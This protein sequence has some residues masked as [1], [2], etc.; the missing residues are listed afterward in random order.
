VPS[1]DGYR[2]QAFERLASTNLEAMRQAVAGVEGNLWIT[3]DTQS[4]GK[5]RRGRIWVSEP[6]N[7]YASLL[8]MENGIQKGI[9]TLPFVASLAVA[10][11]IRSCLKTNDA[12][13]SIKWPNDVLF[14]R[15][16]ISGILLEA[17]VL[18][19]EKH[20]VVIGCGINCM[21]SPENALYPATSLK[22]E[23][24]STK[25]DEMFERLAHFMQYYLE[26]LDQGRGFAP[27]RKKWLAQAAGLGEP[28]VARFDDYTVSGTFNGID[29][30]GLMILTTANGEKLISAADIFF[31][32]S[33]KD[34]GRKQ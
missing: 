18:S 16:K 12:P 14:D 23:G 11:A 13:V 21:H 6:G 24:Y 22:D 3:A 20:A 19:G 17:S 34:D 2:R 27:I 33:P 25:P 28:I 5:A 7:L 26:I 8:L 4:A 31:G 32:N 9:A 30:Q 1:A 15:K 29:A 10:E